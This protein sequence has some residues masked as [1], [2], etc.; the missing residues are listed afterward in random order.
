MDVRGPTAHQPTGS[1][2]RYA[3]TPGGGSWRVSAWSV[4]SRSSKPMCPN[5][6]D[7]SR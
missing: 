1:S 7:G 4:R 6:E 2:P 3:T 5:S